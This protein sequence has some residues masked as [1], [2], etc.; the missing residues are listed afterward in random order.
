MK[1]GH[2]FAPHLVGNEI[3]LPKSA[4]WVPNFRGW[5]FIQVRSGISYWQQPCGMRELPAGSVLVLTGDAQGGLR[6][7]QLSEVLIAYFCV[8]PEK[9]TGLLSFNEQQSLRKAAARASRSIRILPPANPL[10]ERFESLCPGE[11]GASLAN[12]LHLLQLFIDLFKGEFNEAPAVVPV[13]PAAVSEPGARGRLRQLLKQMA[14]SEFLELSLADLVPK[15]GCSARH[16][17]RLF[18]EEVGI[19]FREK[20]TELRLAK[21]CELLATSKTKVI[22][23]ALISGYQSNSLFSL[24]FKKRFGVSPGR[25]RR[26]RAVKSDQRQKFTRMLPA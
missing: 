4:E 17:S 18:R 19:S 2:S 21:A 14:T 16:L 20:Q 10:A 1:A 24:L 15:L 3:R 22:D 6:A 23:V 12:R 25:W 11:N 9:L 26:R 13:A 7:S 5:S 8:E